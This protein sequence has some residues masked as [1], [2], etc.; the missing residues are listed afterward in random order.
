MELPPGART[1]VALLKPAPDSTLVLLDPAG[2]ATFRQ[3]VLPLNFAIDK[4]GEATP[5]GPRHY[6]VSSVRI[7][8]ASLG[9]NERTAVQDMFARGQ[10]RKMPAHEQ[11][12]TR[13]FEPLD[14]GLR[15]TDLGVTRGQPLGRDVQYETVIIDSEWDS[16]TTGTYRPTREF[17]LALLGA[18][19]KVRSLIENTGYAKF[20]PAPN[21]NPQ[22]QLADEQYQ[23]VTAEDLS[24]AR[25]IVAAPTTQG[26]ARDALEAHLANNPQDRGKYQV[27]PTHEAVTV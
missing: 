19:A 8:N 5:L 12:S 4:F 3:R 16:R 9:A 20:G 26:L 24:P 18:S 1:V 21:S 15:I 10:Y 13:S 25:A 2:S 14:S 7:E 6:D 11:L 22:F 17:Q 23:V 27:V